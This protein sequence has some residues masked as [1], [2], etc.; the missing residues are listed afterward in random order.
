M[1]KIL[2]QQAYIFC[3]QLAIVLKTGIP[4]LDGLQVMDNKDI[5]GRV[6]KQI[7]EEVALGQP[8]SKALRKVDCFDEYVVSMVE[9]GEQSGRLD[10]VMESLT[11]YYE[12]NIEMRQKVSDAVNYPFMLTIIM[13]IVIFVIVTK[14]LP[15][16][17][18]VLH[19]IGGDLSPLAKSLM[20][21]GTMIGKYGAALSI[22]MVSVI[23]VI[24]GYIIVMQRIRPTQDPFDILLFRKVRR[25]LAISRLTYALNLLLS[26]GCD[27][28]ESIALLPR[29]VKDK[30]TLIKLEKCQE[31]IA[32]G[33]RIESALLDSE[34]YEGLYGRMLYVGFK[35]G[36]GEVVLKNIVDLSDKDVNDAIV[37]YL[38]I[39]E[40]VMVLTLSFVIGVILLSVMLPLFSIM[41]TLG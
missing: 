21:V 32:N 9:V 31:A 39:I 22:V 23:V 41:A 29:L 7:Q 19:S 2:D 25:K 15:I 34:L 37:R 27:I 20:N 17:R 33:E 16:F 10:Q 14:V 35:S 30:H 28:Q 11:E 26:S 3:S 8:L 5:D 6:M 40:P 38:N 1:K 13:L 24:V 18:N 36:S 12:R 4:I